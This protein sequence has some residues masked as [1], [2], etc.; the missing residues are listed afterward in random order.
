MVWA[1]GS[2]RLAK[3]APDEQEGLMRSFLK[4]MAS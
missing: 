1:S 3:V 4:K 2:L